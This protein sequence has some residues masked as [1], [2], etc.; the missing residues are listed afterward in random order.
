MKTSSTRPEHV[1][2]YRFALG[3]MASSAGIM[4]AT[5]HLSFLET[6][7]AADGPSRHLS[8]LCK[9]RHPIPKEFARREAVDLIYKC[10][11]AAGARPDW[12]TARPL[13]VCLRSTAGNESY[14][15]DVTE[16]SP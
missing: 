2:I 16:T 10:A 5:L 11:V 12:L 6:H 7:S 1:G 8:C 15:G 9:I 14:N 13:S 3:T 4:A